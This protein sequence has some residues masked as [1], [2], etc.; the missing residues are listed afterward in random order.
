MVVG[1]QPKHSRN[2][3]VDFVRGEAYYDGKVKQDKNRGRKGQAV[4][5]AR[6]DIVVIFP[7]PRPSTSMRFS[8]RAYS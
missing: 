2:G 8:A 7:L 6:T 3:T 4:M 1:Y 5:S